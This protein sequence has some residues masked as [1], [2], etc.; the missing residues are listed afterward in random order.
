M[1]AEYSFREFQENQQQ[2]LDRA[3]EAYQAYLEALKGQP[4]P[5]GRHALEEDQGPGILI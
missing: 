3:V 1:A 4:A 5:Q 2:T